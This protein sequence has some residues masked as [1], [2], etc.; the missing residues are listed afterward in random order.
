MRGDILASG[1]S[2]AT[3][4]MQPDKPI[5]SKR[6][7]LTVRERKSVFCG[8][9]DCDFTAYSAVEFSDHIRVCPKNP[10]R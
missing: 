10:V 6:K 4:S 7:V 5:R 8:C 3:W 1:G 9:R 2:T